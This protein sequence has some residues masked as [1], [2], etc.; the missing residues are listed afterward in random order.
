MWPERAGLRRDCQAISIDARR[1]LRGTVGTE[2]GLSQNLLAAV[3]DAMAVFPP[4]TLPDLAEGARHRPLFP[5][6]W[7]KRPIS[8]IFDFARFCPK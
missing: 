6:H 1:Q 8:S 3:I 7:L 2:A 5:C 4:E